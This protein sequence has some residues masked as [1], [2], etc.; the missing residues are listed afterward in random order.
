MKRTYLACVLA[1]AITF[2]GTA[3]ATAHDANDSDHDANN[4]E[5][6]SSISETV[7]KALAEVQHELETGNLPLDH[8]DHDNSKAYITPQGD[9]IIDGNT[10]ATTADQHQLL[11]DY[12]QQTL[13]IAL[14]GI[15]IG[16]QGASLASKAVGQALW[17]VFTGT[18]EAMEKRMEAEGEKIEQLAMTRICP[19]LPRLLAIQQS[20]ADSLP[21][22]KP[23]AKMDADDINECSIKHI[24][25]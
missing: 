17:A 21:E 5:S 18:T 11:L 16:K 8:R 3:G 23:Y 1:A 24:E 13:Q 20:L 7:N 19:Q 10:I 6:P 9:L 14:A 22:F 15:E 2:A 25:R 4:D 12:R